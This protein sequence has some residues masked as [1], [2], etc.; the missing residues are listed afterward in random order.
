MKS[1]RLR[2]KSRFETVVVGLQKR[3]FRIAQEKATVL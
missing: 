1:S 2:F 3:K